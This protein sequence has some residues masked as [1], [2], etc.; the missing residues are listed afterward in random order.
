MTF[1]EWAANPSIMYFRTGL[2]QGLL[3]SFNVAVRNIAYNFH[4]FCFASW[5][6]ASRVK[7]WVLRLI[8]KADP[9]GA[10]ALFGWSAKYVSSAGRFSKPDWRSGR[11]GPHKPVLGEGSLE[12]RWHQ[13]PMKINGERGS[14]NNNK[15]AKDRNKALFFILWCYR[16]WLS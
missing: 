6:P 2:M 14:I 4:I 8:E 1:A 3:S 16:S 10:A 13:S 7:W 11:V 9:G 12:V 15:P 5:M